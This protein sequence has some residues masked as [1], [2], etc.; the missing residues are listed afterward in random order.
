MMNAR[1][2]IFESRLMSTLT[3]STSSSSSSSHGIFKWPK[4]QLHCNIT[5]AQVMH[6]SSFV[7]RMWLVWIGSFLH[8]TAL[9][10]V[11]II[12]I[13]I[14]T[15]MYRFEWNCRKCCNGTILYTSNASHT[16]V[17]AV[18]PLSI[19]CV[20]RVQVLTPL[21]VISALSTFHDK[22]ST[23]ASSWACWYSNCR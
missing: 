15:C 12:I 13:I 14:T 21:S 1:Y 5:Y 9:A 23:S 7:V 3:S 11:F 19:Q 16:T 4:Q 20:T 17:Q 6:E 18:Y 10:R 22:F 8:N 2:S